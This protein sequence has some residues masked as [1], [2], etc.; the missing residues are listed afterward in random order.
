MS[1]LVLARK[2]R[3]KTFSEVVGQP[4][5]TRTLQNAVS[6]GRVAQA[7]LFSGMRGVGKT[8]MARILAKALNCERG[9][10][11]GPCDACGPCREI[12][13]GRSL[14]VVEMDAASNRGID[15]IRRLQ[16]HLLYRGSL[17]HKVVILD[18]AHMLTKEANNAFLKT[19]EEPPPG[20]LFVLATTE[21]HKIEETVLSRCQHFSFRRIDEAEIAKHL[22]HIAEAEKIKISDTALDLVVRES[23]GSMRDAIVSLD[24]L[25]AFVGTDIS[26]ADAAAVLGTIEREVL[27]ALMGAVAKEDSSLVQRLASEGVNLERLMVELVWYLREL[28][29]V[30]TVSEPKEFLRLSERDLEKMKAMASFL[31]ESDLLRALELAARAERELRWSRQPRFLVEAT[32][33]KLAHLKRLTSIEEAIE[34]LQSGNFP[35]GAGGSSV[36]EEFQK[37]STPPAK[38]KSLFQ[39]PGESNNPSAAAKTAKTPA[40][41]DL[42]RPAAGPPPKA[43]NPAAL[44]VT[45]LTPVKTTLREAPSSEE[46]SED[47]TRKLIAY[48]EKERPSLAGALSLASRWDWSDGTLTLRFTPRHGAIRENLEKTHKAELQECLK[49]T[50][51][52]SY[53]LLF[54]SLDP[55]DKDIEAFAGLEDK[56]IQEEH[57]REE[58]MQEP[59]VRRVLDFF[60]GRVVEVEKLD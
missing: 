49:E 9:P 24:Q 32:L 55:S 13:S 40:G 21:P 51:G 25:V 33:L 60:K 53:E 7:Y 46:P 31:S 15:D 45:S 43:E 5:V 47:R 20:V 6:Q 27:H 54:L 14:D 18:E 50:L 57:L 29:V 36:E 19:L 16:E 56:K 42:P 41:A 10:A 44:S 26:D 28:L 38:P 2:W 8:T 12:S 52:Q 34:H 22:R 37:L 39:S 11:D 4:V 58:A 30:K 59:L 48:L 1:Y 35:E 17:R 23:E 3:P